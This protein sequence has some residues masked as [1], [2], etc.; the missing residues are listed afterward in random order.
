[1]IF[2]CDICSNNIV[3]CPLVRQGDTCFI[4]QKTSVSKWNKKG[5]YDVI[6]N[7]RK[8][9][10]KHQQTSNMPSVAL[11]PIIVVTW[12]N[13]LFLDSY[14]SLRNVGKKK[15]ISKKHWCCYCQKAGSHQC[16]PSLYL[17]TKAF[18][19]LMLSRSVALNV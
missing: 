7:T 10:Y 16:H 14:C 15:K 2:H 11:K 5:H 19:L 1:M 6:L 17:Q 9:I 8:N 4:R 12:E 18:L 13:L 3:C